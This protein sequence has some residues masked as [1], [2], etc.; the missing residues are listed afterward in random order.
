[1]TTTLTKT[2]HFQR[3]WRFNMPALVVIYLRF[4]NSTQFTIMNGRWEK[5]VNKGKFTCINPK[6]SSIVDYCLIIKLT[7]FWT[8]FVH[9]VNNPVLKGLCKFQVDIP[10][11]ARVT[12]VQSLENLHTFILQ[13]PCW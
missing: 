9:N 13:Q 6:E 7:I 11:N 12:A 2:Y 4:Y 10:K 1:M 5:G 3:L 8:K